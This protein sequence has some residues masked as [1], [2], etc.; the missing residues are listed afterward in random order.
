MPADKTFA[1][2]YGQMKKAGGYSQAVKGNQ[3][4]PV[5]RTLKILSV[6]EPVCLWSF[7]D[8]SEM[9]YSVP[10]F[11]LAGLRISLSSTT[12]QNYPRQSSQE[13]Q[14]SGK[15]YNCCLLPVISTH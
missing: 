15:F 5:Q 10:V 9:K 11:D 4:L 6:E 8:L 3:P 2:W 12:F 1:Q 14:R 7:V 13:C